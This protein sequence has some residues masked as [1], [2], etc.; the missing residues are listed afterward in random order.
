MLNEQE[1]N[2]KIKELIEQGDPFAVSRVGIG[3]E[4]LTAYLTDIGQPITP[5]VDHMNRI[6]AGFY[7]DCVPQF[8]KEYTKGI[9]CADIQIEW[10]NPLINKAQTHLFDKY[11]PNSIRVHNRSLEPFYFDNPWS[12]ELK[13]KKVLII[14]PFKKSIEEQYKKRENLFQNKKILP[15]FDLMCYQSVQSIGGEGPHSDWI[16]SLNIMKDDISKYDFDIALV[17]CGA[18]GL[19]LVNFIKTELNKSAIYIGGGVQILFGIK[20]KRWDGHGII[21][22]LYN[23]HWVYPKAEEKHDKAHMAEGGSYWG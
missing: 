14:H 1:G 19:P 12:E 17:G 16:E 6:V 22:K 2:D 11:S 8:H 13:G 18:Y 21:S 5:N 10:N 15:E 23:E 4:T 9:A 20:G 7:G 3:G